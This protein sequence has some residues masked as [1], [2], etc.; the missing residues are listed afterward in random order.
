MFNKITVRGRLILLGV[1]SVL[2]LLVVGGVGVYATA[3]L[4]DALDTSFI[5]LQASSNE[6]M[7]DMMHDAL[8]ADV[9]QALRGAQRAD[10]EL[11]KAAVEDAKKHAEE[12]AKMWQANEALPL[13]EDMKVLIKKVSPEVSAYRND[14]VRLVNLAKTDAAAAEAD[15]VGF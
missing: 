11:S 13:A 14:A 15:S 10:A 7:A 8:R 5:N 6:G 9:L 3:T 1:V 12:F 4:S 2:M